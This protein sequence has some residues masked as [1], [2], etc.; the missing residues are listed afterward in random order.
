L[1]RNKKLRRK[2]LEPGLFQRSATKKL[3]KIIHLEIL[4][5]SSLLGSALLVGGFY[6]FGALRK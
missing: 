1:R 4:L 5:E 2:S 6:A 3:E